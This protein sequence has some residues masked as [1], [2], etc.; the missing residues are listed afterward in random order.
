MNHRKSSSRNQ[1][2]PGCAHNIVQGAL[3]FRPGDGLRFIGANNAVSGRHVR[4]IAGD[5]RKGGRT[6][7]LGGCPD[8]SGQNPDILSDTVIIHGFL[9]NLSGPLLNFK[10]CD[11]R[12]ETPLFIF[13]LKNQRNG[14]EARSHIE[15]SI[16]FFQRRIMR[17]ENCVDAKAEH[18]GVLP[19]KV[20]ILQIIEPQH[21]LSPSCVS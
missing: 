14:R 19:D 9:R 10:T 18:S 15:Y 6:H 11:V 4:R 12:T 8:I 16:M 13:R 17:E 2:S 3:H 1:Q 7:C 5:Q 20:A 21:Q